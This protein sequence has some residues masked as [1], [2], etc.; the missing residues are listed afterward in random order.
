MEQKELLGR[1]F[2]K[3][4]IPILHIQLTELPEFTRVPF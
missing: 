4:R 2:T 3:R 1:K